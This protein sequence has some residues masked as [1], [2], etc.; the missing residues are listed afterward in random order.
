[1]RVATIIVCDIIE[2]L[3]SFEENPGEKYSIL[4]FLPG[5][6]EIF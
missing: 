4:I 6:A 3:N 5:L 2:K 1:M